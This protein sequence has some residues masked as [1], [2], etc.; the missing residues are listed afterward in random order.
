MT[1]TSC[2]T[3][4]FMRHHS[5]ILKDALRKVGICEAV[6]G[7]LDTS[8]RHFHSFCY[9]WTWEKPYS[10]PLSQGLRVFLCPDETE[11]LQQCLFLDFQTY[12]VFLLP[13]PLG[14]RNL[15]SLLGPEWRW[16]KAGGLIGSDKA[17]LTADN[18]VFPSN[19][20]DLSS[21]WV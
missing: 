8:F 10:W 12:W 9:F 17:D 21:L 7:C 20:Y 1:V 19:F 2:A 14:R 16:Q 15:G 13:L 3:L 5:A 6:L 11:C 4:R 18:S